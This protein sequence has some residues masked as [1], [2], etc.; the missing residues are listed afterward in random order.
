MADF[1]LI[2]IFHHYIFQQQLQLNQK[3]FLDFFFLCVWVGC[4][5]GVGAGE[6]EKGERMGE[7][8]KGTRERTGERERERSWSVNEKKG[9]KRMTTNTTLL[10]QQQQ[11]CSIFLIDL[12]L[13]CFLHHQMSF[14][15]RMFLVV[16]HQLVWVQEW[17]GSYHHGTAHPATQQSSSFFHQTRQPAKK[18]EEEEERRQRKKTKKKKV[19]SVFRNKKKL[20]KSR[21]TRGKERIISKILQE[22]LD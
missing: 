15:Q 21:I 10:R 16:Q 5:W 13:T 14:P 1:V 7:M 17:R 3:M 2:L 18:R 20:Y 12:L 22:A 19:W 11:K 8:E 9:D 6:R 4:G